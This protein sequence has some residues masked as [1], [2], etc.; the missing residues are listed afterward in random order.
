MLTPPLCVVVCVQVQTASPCVNPRT[1][2]WETCQPNCCCTTHPRSF[3][4]DTVVHFCVW[5]YVTIQSANTATLH[6][7]SFCPQACR[8]PICLDLSPNMLHGR[9]TGNKVVNWDVKVGAHTVVVSADTLIW[10]VGPISA[11][12]KLFFWSVVYWQ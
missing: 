2:S 12:R 9:L 11:L 7:S 10:D 4:S 1:R 8:N 5:F 3:E 6:T